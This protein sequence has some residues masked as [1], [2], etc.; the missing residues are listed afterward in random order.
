MIPNTQKTS[1]LVPYQ[2]PG[3]VRDNPEYS[4]FQVF[5]QAYYEWLE[6]ANSSNSAIDTATSSM[7]GVGFASSN[8]LQYTDI[9]TTIHDFIDY[10]INDFLPYF[11]KDSLVS[12]Q[13]AIKFA[14]ELYQAKGTPA[15]YQFLFRVLYNSDFQYYKTSDTI[16]RASAGTWYVAKSLKLATSDLRFLQTK[17]LR[18]FGETSKSI[19]TI[20]NAILVGNK[21][22]VFISNIERL[23]E[24]GETIR[25]VNN[26]NQDVLI[27]GTPLTSKVVGQVS[28]IN[29][30]TNDKGVPLNR[31]T[32]YQVGDPVIVYGG[33]NPDIQ[34]P[35]G[36]TAEIGSVTSGAI[37][38]INT[39]KGG[40]GYSLFPNTKL[41][42]T[43]APGANAI[44]Y[45]VDPNVNTQANVVMFPTDSIYGKLAVRINAN[46][47]NFI[48]SSWSNANT[49]IG[50]TL[51]FISFATY[52]ISSVAVIN[53]GGGIS[54]IPT[55][56]AY[57]TQK[58]DINGEAY[59][60]KLGILAPIQ[61]ANAGRGYRAND[62]IRITGGNGYG[63]RAN[64]T[65]V[66]S[67]G[68]ITGVRYV[69]QSNTARPQNYPLGG[70]G[71]TNEFL[72]TVT[73]ISSNTQAANASLF[74]PGILGAGASFSVATQ[75]IGS[76]TTIN[77]TN[78]G[79]DYV[80]SP[81]VSLSVQDILVSNADILLLPA[82]GDF[83]YQGN[84]PKTTSY[85]ALVDSVRLLNGDINTFNSLYNI[86]VF[87]YNSQPNPRLPLVI[88]NKNINLRMA[89]TAAEA[90]KYY[91]GS[92]EYNGF[93]IKNYG[94][95]QAVAQ[96]SFLNGLVFSQGQYLD[97]SGQPSSF[98]VLESDI[99]NDFTYQITVEKEIEKYRNVVLNLLHPAGTKLR[100][101]YALRSNKNVKIASQNALYKATHLQDYT[102][103]SASEAK[104][105][106]N[107]TNHSN[108]IVSFSNTAGA[109]IATFIFTDVP[110]TPNSVF[111]MTTPHGPNVRSEVVGVDYANNKITLKD[112]VFLTY[113]NV[114]Y[115]AA[116][117]NTKIINIK[118][119]TN[120]YNVMNNGVY[121][122]T[123]YPLKD[124][125]FAGDTIKIST[126]TFTVS[127]VNY[128]TGILYVSANVT[129][130]I[131]NSFVSVSRTI[132]ASGKSVRI[133][134]P[135][136]LEYVPE[137]ITEDGLTITTE[138]GSIIILE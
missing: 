5:L 133:I 87:N 43:N 37:T 46:N 136:G 34:T 92:P 18:V 111:A 122:N 26:D 65:S 106:A 71:Y 54:T 1:L 42:I 35:V 33:L 21:I 116:N 77:L 75:K 113:S 55:V 117:A 58:T 7:Q 128:Q 2:L 63:A 79:E 15:S 40:F 112:S 90:N 45:S 49:S 24:S 66:N 125:V 14:R 32:L 97:T 12:Q 22:E 96:A 50:N 27:N 72:P 94:D 123:A 83:I 59:L 110:G 89:N 132:Q 127:S 137:L 88:E 102:G 19:A 99:Y 4:N 69:Y 39:I 10:F 61:I 100:G 11:P 118:A 138:N 101:R 31:G 29:L 93:G 81:N 85:S 44:V 56:I 38:G 62:I 25:I 91:I 120:A 130:N 9:D 30:K 82:A 47:Y 74:V 107:F 76:V 28:Q 84:S 57:N 119:I 6:L 52:P 98:D 20:E 41:T 135:I 124:I 53:G 105:V 67:A 70:M 86:R 16:L 68:S 3:F 104:I 13:K 109:N 121:S 60:N 108:N 64:I 17:N 129:S 73:V 95:G 8:I 36:A 48:N 115:V 114:A 134:G 78:N 103:D 23:F 80:S 126:N 51:N 131:A